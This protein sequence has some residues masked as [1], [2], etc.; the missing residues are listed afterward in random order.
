MNYLQEP[1]L[2]SRGRESEPEH[3]G[4]DSYPT[5]DITTGYPPRGLQVF[6]L[7]YC[8]INDRDTLKYF[9]YRIS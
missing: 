2:S 1:L 3:G 6:V 4:G 9:F 8:Y 5:R 7:D